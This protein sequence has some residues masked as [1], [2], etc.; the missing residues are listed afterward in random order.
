VERQGLKQIQV[1]T[2]GVIK[3]KGSVDFSCPDCEVTISLEDETESVHSALET[4]V[5]MYLYIGR[6]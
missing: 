4:N 2:V 5:E 3:I 1:S 6:R